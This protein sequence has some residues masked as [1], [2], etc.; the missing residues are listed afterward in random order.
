MNLFTKIFLFL[1]PISL[2]QS[3]DCKS[4]LII[5]T[6]IIPVN[7]LI[8]DSLV[9]EESIFNAKL[10]DGIYKIIVME[11]VDRL[12]AKMFIDSIELKNCEEKKLVYKDQ[13]K[14]YLD[15]S[16][17]DA[18][19]F[20]G[21]SLLGN[22]PLFIPKSFNE[23]RL[24]KPQFEEKVVFNSQ[25]MENSIVNLNFIGNHKEESFFYSTTFKILAGTAL[26]LGAASAYYKLKADDA[27]D[28]YQYTGNKD[29][30]D[31]TN[32]YDVVSGVTFTA[33][34]I[35]FGYILYR[36]LTE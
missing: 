31:E 23:L 20:M 32:K 10:A 16:P 21:D 22:T 11:N 6:D 13:K 15:S 9:S 1:I 28:E 3:Q 14:V 29:K 2:I 5:E 34:Q 7:I 19:V 12:D 36:F 8:N 4:T 30:L 27:F 17:Q 26:V 35:N 33:L 18:Y 24:T 25:I